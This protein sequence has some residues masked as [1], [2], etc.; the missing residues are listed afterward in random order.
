MEHLLDVS[1]VHTLL[2]RLQRWK[3]GIII[4]VLQREKLRLSKV[5]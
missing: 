2:T 5:W 4:P 1:A 3:V